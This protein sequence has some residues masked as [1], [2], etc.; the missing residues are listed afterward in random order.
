VTDG[1]ENLEAELSRMR[2]RQMSEAL[3]ARIDEQLRLPRGSAW[4]DRFLVTAMS[5]GAM[6]ACVIV[7]MF[8]CGASPSPNNDLM[9]MTIAA[10]P[11]APPVA[12]ARADAQWFDPSR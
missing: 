8:I 1:T 9:T 3:V 10:S 5:G 7:A 2:P 6:A 11:N 4:P 12:L